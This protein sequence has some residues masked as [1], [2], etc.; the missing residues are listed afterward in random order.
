ML[1]SVGEA[2]QP[3]PAKE[4]YQMKLTKNDAQEVL[5][6][7][8]VLA[9][10]TDLQEDYG[11]TQEQADTLRDSV[12][13]LGGEWEVPAWAAEVVKGEME[14]HCTVMEAM[15]AD[16]RS[17]RQNGQALQLNKQATRLSEIFVEG[18]K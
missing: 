3:K 2:I 17:D 7:M 11:I 10:T 15:A 9:D 13:G 18:S 8:C 12:P 16:A 6:K 5:H 14:D 1:L 4:N